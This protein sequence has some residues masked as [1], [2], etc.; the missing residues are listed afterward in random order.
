MQGFVFHVNVT[1]RL[2]QLLK[3]FKVAP[4]FGSYF[5][6]ILVSQ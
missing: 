5:E 1:L 4:V 2:L 6:H 3:Y